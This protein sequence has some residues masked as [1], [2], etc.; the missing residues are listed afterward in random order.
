MLQLPDTLEPPNFATRGESPTRRS[1]WNG[2]D[3]VF[4]PLHF[5]PHDRNFWPVSFPWPGIWR[6][7]SSSDRTLRKGLVDTGVVAPMGVGHDW[8]G[9]GRR[10]DGGWRH[11]CWIHNRPRGIV[12]T[13]LGRGTAPSS[14]CRDFPANIIQSRWFSAIPRRRTEP[15]RYDTL[16]G[17]V[18]DTSV[19]SKSVSDT[20][21]RRSRDSPGWILFPD[22]E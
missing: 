20:L 17:R 16:L 18:D 14:T 9:R 5:H 11:F 12:A 6:V 8:G 3:H 22:L 7:C 21:S 4:G 19:L 15:G 13:Q 10:D 1:L 2:F